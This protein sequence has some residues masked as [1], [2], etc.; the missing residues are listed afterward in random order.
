VLREGLRLNPYLNSVRF[1]LMNEARG[2]RQRIL[3]SEFQQLR[4]AFWEKAVG[5]RYFDMGPYA[6]VIGR[7]KDSHPP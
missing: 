5:T 1:R 2:D 4:T 6:E 3:M 7:S